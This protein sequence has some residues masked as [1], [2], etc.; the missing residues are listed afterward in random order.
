MATGKTRSASLADDLSIA[1][2]GDAGEGQ[3]RAVDTSK[4][5]P[6]S[7]LRGGLSH[8][9]QGLNGELANAQ[10]ALEFLD[11]SASQLQSLKTELSAR[12]AGHQARDNQLDAKLRQFS[13]TWD[14]RQAQSGGSLSSQL[15]YSSPAPATQRFSIR[16]LNL[17]TLQSGARETLSISVGGAGQSLRSVTID[18]GLSADEIVRRFDQALAPANIRVGT[19]DAGA[20]I[21]STTE[22]AWA[23]VRDTLSIKGDGIRFPTGQLS[24]VKADAEPAAIQPAGW[25]ASDVETMRQT[26]QQV[27][28]ALNRVMHAREA[29]SRALALA[30]HRVDQAA[31][32]YDA[33]TLASLAENFAGKAGQSGYPSLSSMTAAL[34][35]VSRDRVLSLLSLR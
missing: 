31:P 15:A 18:P 21:F 9:D 2:A 12:L 28:Q 10:Q 23:S 29:V 6:A 30:N 27:V 11:Q 20:L 33:A 7:T 32:G 19:D 26:L 22:T 4:P 3:T 34:L 16:G 35:G 14:Q 8:W 13:A 17:K 24:R 5:G 25:Q 1:L